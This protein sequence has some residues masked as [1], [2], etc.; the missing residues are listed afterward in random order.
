[1][2]LPAALF[3]A[4]AF[5]VAGV[6]IVPA[7]RRTGLGRW[8]PAVAWLALELVFFGVGSVVIAIEGNAGVALYVAGAVVAFAVAI[9]ASNDVARRRAAIPAG[10]LAVLDAP[11]LAP[12]RPVVA[13]VLVAVGVLAIVPILLRVGI[14]FLVPDITAARV[15]VAGPAVQVLRVAI[16]GAVT[17]AIV[18][19]LR[20]RARVAGW[21]AVGLLAVAMLF[22]VM[23]AS[24][25]LAVELVAAT[26]IAAGLAGARLSRPAVVAV[27]AA[28]VLAFGG[29]QVLRAYEQAAGHEVMFGVTRTVERLFIIQP[30]T[31]EELQAEIPAHEP[32]FGGLTWLRQLGPTLGRADIPN[33]GYWI[34]ARLFP[35]QEPPGYAAPGLIGEAWANFGTAGIALFAGLGVAVERAGALIARRRV[36]TADIAAAA[37][38]VLF[39]ARTHALGL[40]GLAVLVLLVTAWRLLVARPTGL[41]DDLG[42]TLRW[43]T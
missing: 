2:N 39:I 3:V 30:R 36:G 37:L 12:V 23:L 29:I 7:C 35:G 16:P 14:P 28:A 38:L 21:I 22:D 4:V 34:Y 9:W 18:V 11:D 17:A 10:G 33:L 1:M 19:F 13:G 40:N 42:A 26:V 25:F 32:F 20:R 24:R 8:H 6:L 31:L 41:V 27:G 43:R 15:E 5:V